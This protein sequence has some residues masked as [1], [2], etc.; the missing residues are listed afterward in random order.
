M[1]YTHGF[2][3]LHDT[4]F[5][6]ILSVYSQ[7][8]YKSQYHFSSGKGKHY[9]IAFLY[10][11]WTIHREWGSTPSRSS[12]IYTPI[13]STVW[14]NATRSLMFPF[15]GNFIIFLFVFSLMLFWKHLNKRNSHK[16][17]D[18]H[19]F[20]LI[21][22]TREVSRSSWFTRWYVPGTYILWRTV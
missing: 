6:S 12:P 5:L 11:L 15:H 9:L 14:K 19:F 7:S 10:F 4:N 16:K 3:L 21:I 2:M 22:L 18:I 8:L 1:N 13:S 17:T 20:P